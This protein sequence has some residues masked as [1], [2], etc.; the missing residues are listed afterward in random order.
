MAREGSHLFTLIVAGLSGAAALAAYPA[1]A[2][3]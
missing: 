1:D 3:A 2:R